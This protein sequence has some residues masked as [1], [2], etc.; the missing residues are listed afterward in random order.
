MTPTESRKD[1]QGKARWSLLPWASVAEVVGV[2]D[3]GAAKYAPHAWQGVPDAQ[4][5][6]FDALVRHLTAWQQGERYDRESGKLHL[7]HVACNA[8]FL[9]WFDLRTE[10][11]EIQQ[12][13]EDG[14]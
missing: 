4:G 9:I 1:D 7:A 12:A 11:K 8:L 2:L 13:T 6:Y 5:R 14:L 10:Q 3:F